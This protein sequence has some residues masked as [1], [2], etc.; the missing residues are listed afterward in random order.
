MP[1][2]TTRFLRKTTK[3][4][5]ER[6]DD[7]G[8]VLDLEETSLSGYA[9]FED[10][11]YFFVPGVINEERPF[12]VGKISI[13]PQE[14]KENSAIIYSERFECNFRCLVPEIKLL[15][16]VHQGIFRSLI[17]AEQKKQQIEFAFKIL[18]PASNARQEF[19]E[20]KLIDINI[21]SAEYR[22]REWFSTK[23]MRQVE[24]TLLNEFCN[25]RS[26]GQVPLIC[27]E[28]AK[29]FQTEE[30]FESRHTLLPKIFELISNIRDAF[31]EEAERP[32]VNVDT[33][34][35][36][37]SENIFT[38]TGANFRQALSTLS[39][40]KTQRETS[41]HYNRLTKNLNV[42]ETL[43]NGPK[44]PTWALEG[45]AESY[46][47]TR[48]VKSRF[49]ES[50]LIERLLVADLVDVASELI[51]SHNMPPEVNFDFFGN[52]SDQS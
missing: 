42:T 18:E 49:L 34:S 4:F 52:S 37:G 2:V 16:N 38:L 41:E 26:R 46:V 8:V 17:E 15:V 24:T 20:C 9:Y 36:I 44:V 39:D 48:I 3:V 30:I 43:R 6:G 25:D 33:E 11:L 21:H 1:Y 40:K 14:I 29:T 12:S 23:L 50:L 22:Y 45:I 35:G 7:D 28:M 47:E 13:R 27:S 32:Q 51:R 10:P 5:R 19:A 31:E